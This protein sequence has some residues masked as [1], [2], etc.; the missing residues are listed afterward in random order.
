MKKSN[1][2]R[3]TAVLVAALLI[4]TTGCSKDKSSTLSTVVRKSKLIKDIDPD[5]LAM[6]AI[7]GYVLPSEAN[8]E[9]NIFNENTEFR[10]ST[11]ADPESG[12]YSFEKVPQG[13]YIIEVIPTVDQLFNTVR[14]K[15]VLVIAET[16]TEL[17][18]NLSK[19]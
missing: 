5:Y 17:N 12:L 3:F 11:K 16:T 9:I 15:N 6:G 4:L 19:K 10:M 18:F 7:K 2:L 14:L 13:V 8:A 1:S